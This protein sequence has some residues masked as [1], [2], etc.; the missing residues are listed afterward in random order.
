MRTIQPSPTRMHFEGYRNTAGIAAIFDSACCLKRACG[1]AH[2][3]ED[4]A[5]DRLF[6]RT[7]KVIVTAAEARFAFS[8][9]A[10]TVSSSANATPIRRLPDRSGLPNKRN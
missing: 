5:L 10:S 2:L 1:A 6:S 4:K 9:A 7:Y 8:T 3:K